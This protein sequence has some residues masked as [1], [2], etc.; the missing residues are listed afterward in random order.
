MEQ[1][2]ND[3]TIIIEEDILQRGMIYYQKVILGLCQLSKSKNGYFFEV[4]NDNFKCKYST[5]FS[6]YNQNEI[7]NVSDLPENTFP[8]FWRADIV[9]FIY[10]DNMDAMNNIISSY[11]TR[12]HHIIAIGIIFSMLKDVKYKLIQSTSI[13]INKR[14]RYIADIV[15][16]FTPRTDS[17]RKNLEQLNQLIS[18]IM[19]INNDVSDYAVLDAEKL[20]LH[21]EDT[22]IRDVISGVHDIVLNLYK[23]PPQIVIDPSVPEVLVFD[24]E[25]LIQ[26][27][28]YVLSSVAKGDGKVTITLQADDYS[29]LGL[30]EVALKI[31]VTPE[32]ISI[33]TQFLNAS[34]T[35]VETLSIYNSKKLCEMMKGT[36]TIVPEGLIITIICEKPL[37]ESLKNKNIVIAV[38]DAHLRSDINDIFV[39]LGA[40]PISINDWR[41]LKTNVNVDLVITDTF[42]SGFARYFRNKR[43]PAMGI[44]ESDQDRYKFADEFNTLMN[45]PIDMNEFKERCIS[46]LRS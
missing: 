8:I 30:N 13:E 7:Y 32:S 28:V 42:N 18:E 43:V 29:K 1:D 6:M 41:G 14:I 3:L 12:L 40:S 23:I 45:K 38:N 27:L 20:D 9:A 26:I 15:G 21:P 39:I 11:R 33:L 24:K 31:I 5:D 17:Q 4:F 10:V 44:L 35:S 37:N 46:L 25:R 22:N 34:A 2:N 36:M 16:S 19:T